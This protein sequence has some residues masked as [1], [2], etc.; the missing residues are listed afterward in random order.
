VKTSSDLGRGL[1]RGTKL[2]F[3]NEVID[4]HTSL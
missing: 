4:L 1:E 2:V 3:K